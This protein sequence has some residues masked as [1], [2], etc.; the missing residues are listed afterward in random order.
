MDAFILRDVMV[1][2]RAGQWGSGS[3]PAGGL[4]D[5]IVVVTLTASQMGIY[6]RPPSEIKSTDLA[7]TSEPP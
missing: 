6:S 4:G 7:T 1:G 5:M 3:R 2:V